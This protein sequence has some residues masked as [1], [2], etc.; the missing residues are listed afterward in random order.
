LSAMEDSVSHLIFL[1]GHMPT[2]SQTPGLLFLVVSVELLS[3]LKKEGTEY[4][5]GVLVDTHEVI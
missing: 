2:F 5:Q 3:C 4:I 1:R